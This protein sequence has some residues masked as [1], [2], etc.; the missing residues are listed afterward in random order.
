MV[1]FSPV[2]RSR[3]KSLCVPPYTYYSNVG[4]VV[5]SLSRIL[6]HQGE[7]TYIQSTKDF[8]LLQ[9]YVEVMWLGLRGLASTITDRV[10]LFV[11][12][13]LRGFRSDGTRIYASLTGS[14][15]FIRE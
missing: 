6:T 4:K 13:A 5:P 12:L 1:G 8:H 2:S 10:C 3:S 15:K 7:P 14:Q 11:C 9:L